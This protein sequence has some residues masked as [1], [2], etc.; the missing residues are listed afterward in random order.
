[1]EDQFFR[2][3]HTVND[4]I[5][6]SPQHVQQIISQAQVM[7]RDMLAQ[8]MDRIRWNYQSCVLTQPSDSD[9]ETTCLLA[10]LK[11]NVHNRILS[12]QQ[13][14]NS[15]SSQPIRA[16]LL[17][18]IA[19]YYAYAMRLLEIYK[20]RATELY[21]TAYEKLDRSRPRIQSSTPCVSS[22]AS[23]TSLTQSIESLLHSLRTII[24]RWAPT[25]ENEPE[26][27]SP[28]T[29]AEE[30]H[31]L[32]SRGP[33]PSSATWGGQ[34]MSSVQSDRDDVSSLISDGSHLTQSSVDFV[35]L[36]S[37]HRSHHVPHVS[38]L[39]KG[40]EGL[41]E[42]DSQTCL[43]AVET[44]KGM[45]VERKGAPLKQPGLSRKLYIKHTL[46]KDAI[47][48][49]GGLRAFVKRFPDEFRIFPGKGTVWFVT[50]RDGL[51]PSALELEETADE[52]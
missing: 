11:E 2:A 35:S 42:Q 21:Q 46:F 14:V 15:S 4:A 6:S 36:E 28:S 5:T 43:L 39:G 51:P 18:V 8:H 29:E 48:N 16:V 9:V 34:S 13:I 1:M 22:L 44:L 19:D 7:S 32:F 33:S 27:T 10:R 40:T 47:N 20:V 12:W 23:W 3:V 17:G 30:D 45:L 31:N 41:T 37:N 24:Q 26:T 38:V 25:A 50:L 49:A 52:Q